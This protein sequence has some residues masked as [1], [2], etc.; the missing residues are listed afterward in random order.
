MDFRELCAVCKHRAMDRITRTG[1]SQN[2]AH[3][4]GKFT[5]KACS[6]SQQFITAFRWRRQSEIMP[7]IARRIAETYELPI[8]GVVE[9][10]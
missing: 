10:V 3:D 2:R 8:G 9:A 4:V 1:V 5:N 6:A 7:V